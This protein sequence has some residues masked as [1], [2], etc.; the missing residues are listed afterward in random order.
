MEQPQRDQKSAGTGRLLLFGFFCFVILFGWNI[1]QTT[2]WPPAPRDPNQ[3]AELDGDAGVEEGGEGA[4]EKPAEGGEAKPGEGGEQKP[5]E[6]KLGEAPDQPQEP[7]F[8]LPE[9][10]AR[11]VVLGSPDPKSGFTMSIAVESLGAGVRSAT[12]NGKQY[13]VA[14]L[15]K[16]F[17]E[18]KPRPQLSVLGNNI[19]GDEP[20]HE[21]ALA[22]RPELSFDLAVASVDKAWRKVDPEASLKTLHWRLAKSETIPRTNF[23]SSATFEIKS[24]DG[25]LTFRKTFSVNR[26]VEEKPDPTKKEL[27]EEEEEKAAAERVAANMLD[28]TIQIV[29]N[30]SDDA[31]LQYVLQGPVGLPLENEKNARKFRDIQVGFTDDQGEV[32]ADTLTAADVVGQVNDNDVVLWSKPLKYIGVDVQ[33]FAALMFPAGNQVTNNYFDSIEPVLIGPGQEKK[34]WHDVSVELTSREIT[35]K[36][37]RSATDRFQVYLGPK[38]IASLVDLKADGIIDAGWFPSIRHVMVW[39]L[40]KFHGWGLPFGLAIIL[41]TVC[42]RCCMF[43]ISR[44]MARSQKRMKDLQPQIAE[45]K[46]KYKD[47]PQKMSQAQMALWRKEGVNPLGG[48]LP[49]LCQLPIFVALYSA[50]YSWVDLRMASFLWID[51][52]AAPDHLGDFPFDIWFLGEWFNLLPLITVGL[53]YGQQKMTMPPPI[54]DEMA[55]QQKMMTF[56]MLFMGF[57]FY[58]FPAGLNV[59]FIASS[60]WGMCERKILE[61]IP[62]KAVDPAKKEA[63]RKKKENS[64]FARMMKNAMEAADLQKQLESQRD[65][66][67][68]KQPPGDGPGPGG[69]SGS[70]GKGKKKNRRR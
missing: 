51:N 58:S 62:E 12:L 7:E 61:M 9:H 47:E 2:L 6:V 44:K 69:K 5:G 13:V 64:W 70:S 34:Q 63:R 19:S 4:A 35:I 16:N 60:L 10:P 39:L 38:R 21:V 59:Y 11:T 20:F 53:F 46:E 27:S 17:P 23:I 43:P 57:L 68:G 30:G 1:L 45:L 42:V 52:L 56:M 18:G 37:D 65:G 14:D 8:K 24:P 29:N 48:C 26:A 55:M 54:N 15:P 49:A 25:K 66:T 33:Y 22:K 40:D 36:P 67:A 28:V 41:L 50:L 3:I 32:S 31:S